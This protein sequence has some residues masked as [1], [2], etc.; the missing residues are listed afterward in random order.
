MNHNLI[1]PAHPTNLPVF[2]DLIDEPVCTIPM[3]PL[4]PNEVDP[5]PEASNI[6]VLPHSIPLADVTNTHQR[7]PHK[8]LSVRRNNRPDPPSKYTS[9]K[10]LHMLV[11]SLY[12]HLDEGDKALAAAYAREDLANFENGRIREQLYGKKSGRAKTTTIHTGARILTAEAGQVALTT[13]EWKRVLGVIT[14]ELGPLVKLTTKVSNSIEKEQEG[15]MVCNEMA[16]IKKALEPVKEAEK[17]K[18]S[19]EKKLKTAQD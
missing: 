3:H 4:F 17:A 7:Q 8:H 11:G 13:V 16:K 19:V 9:N 10:E 5:V 15:K 6:P 14:K 18:K 1:I 12:S 2:L